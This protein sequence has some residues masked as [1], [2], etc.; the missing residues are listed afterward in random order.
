MSGQGATFGMAALPE[1]IPG[2]AAHV[3]LTRPRSMAQEQVV[4]DGSSIIW[5]V[6]GYLADVGD[7]PSPPCSQ[8]ASADL[9]LQPVNRLSSFVQTV[10]EPLAATEKRSRKKHSEREN[11]DCRG[12]PPR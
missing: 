7:I 1:V 8:L 10:L 3:V 5:N 2:E 4:R 9:I 11:H 12:M 6:P